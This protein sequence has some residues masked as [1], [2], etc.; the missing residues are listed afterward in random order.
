MLHA[1]ELTQELWAEACNTAVYILN[2]SGPTPMKG[3]TP[4]ELWTGSYATLGHLRV[5]GQNVMC[6]FPNRKGTIG[7]KKV[8]WV[9]YSVTW[10]KKMTIEF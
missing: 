8:G 9:D 1:S 7:T 6:T 4:L 10:V 3:K 5:W 2:I